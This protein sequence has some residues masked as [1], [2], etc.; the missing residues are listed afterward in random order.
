MKSFLKFA[1]PFLIVGSIFMGW[2]EYAAVNDV[3]NRVLS[4]MVKT[5]LGLPDQLGSTLVYGF[6]RKELVVVMANS[7]FGVKDI[8]GLPMSWQ[9]VLVFIVF[10]TLYF[11]CFSTFV[12]MW[13]E[14][15]KKVVL[16]SSLLSIIVASIAAFLVKIVLI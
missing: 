12:A 10:V 16:L 8:S 5:V 6:F 7:A 4:P 11:P 9:Q 13:K 1:V 2:L 15:G 3:I 14:F